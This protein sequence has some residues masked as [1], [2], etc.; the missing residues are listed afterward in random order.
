MWV[1]RVEFVGG[2]VW[3]AH[4]RAAAWPIPARAAAS[5]ISEVPVEAV[6]S[7]AAFQAGG[8]NAPTVAVAAPRGEQ[9]AMSSPHRQVETSPV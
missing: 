7:D 6:R 5:R 2:R 3:M 9:R 4:P 1:L 8:L